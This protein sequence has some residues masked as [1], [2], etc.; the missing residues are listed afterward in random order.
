LLGKQRRQEKSRLYEEYKAGKLEKRR[1]AAKT[2]RLGSNYREGGADKA[3]ASYMPASLLPPLSET[4]TSNNFAQK[5]RLNIETSEIHHGQDNKS[6]KE[7]RDKMDR[8]ISSSSSKESD[9]D[10]YLYRQPALNKALWE[11]EPRP[12]FD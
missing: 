12:Y 9:D 4:I 1:N 2:S 10:F 11:T 6:V 7:D 8:M 3:R 5:L